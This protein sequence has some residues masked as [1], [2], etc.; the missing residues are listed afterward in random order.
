MDTVGYNTRENSRVFYILLFLAVGVSIGLTYYHSIVLQDYAAFTDPET[1]PEASD[2]I[3]YLAT[4][5]GSYF[6]K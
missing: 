3:A 6:Q 5:L 4:E 2:F 1:V